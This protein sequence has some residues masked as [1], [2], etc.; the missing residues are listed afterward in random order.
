MIKKIMGKI[1]IVIIYLFV[2]TI[3]SQTSSDYDKLG[4]E[5]DQA[6]NYRG[7][8]KNYEKALQLDPNNIPILEKLFFA[9]CNYSKDKGALDVIS[10]LITLHPESSKFYFLKAATHS[11][12]KNYSAAIN[13]YTQAINKQE[14]KISDFTIYSERGL[15]KFRLKDYKGALAD[16][17]Q[18]LSVYPN[19]GV[20]K[21]KNE[22]ESQI[23]ERESQIKYR[24]IPVSA[25]HIYL[26]K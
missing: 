7:A 18:T 3:Y 17:N 16:F 6:R 8:I 10:K 25:Q 26:H 24:A 12:L 5:M 11:K 9:K 22:A 21:Y 20:L 23:K 19:P 1:I 15:C 14:N 2:S 13:D 4:S